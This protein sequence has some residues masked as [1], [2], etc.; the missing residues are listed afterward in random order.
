ADSRPLHQGGSD[1]NSSRRINASNLGHFYLL[2]QSI[3]SPAR[4]TCQENCTLFPIHATAL[5]SRGAGLAY[6]LGI[7]RDRLLTRRSETPSKKRRGGRES[8]WTGQ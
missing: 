2:R 8:I 4:T 5:P 3:P 6:L 7:L 1:R